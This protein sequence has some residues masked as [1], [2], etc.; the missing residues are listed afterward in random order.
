MLRVEAARELDACWAESSA[1]AQVAGRLV[2]AR[3]SAE[4]ELYGPGD[5][6][7]KV[8][9]GRI[10]LLGEMSEVWAASRCRVVENFQSVGEARAIF[11]VSDHR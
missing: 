4:K 7:A 8:P 11:S 6:C 3:R 10:G 1:R 5:V 9:A 2:D